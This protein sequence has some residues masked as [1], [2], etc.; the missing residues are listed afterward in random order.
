MTFVQWKIFAFCLRVI[1]PFEKAPHMVQIGHV[2]FMHHIYHQ[3]GA[4]LKVR[5]R[6]D[7]YK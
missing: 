1:C 2:Q 5:L 3:W 7:Y 4:R 6:V